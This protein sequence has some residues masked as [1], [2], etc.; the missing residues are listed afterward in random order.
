MPRPASRSRGPWERCALAKEAACSGRDSK[1]VA[2]IRPGI[3]LPLT[4]GASLFGAYFR[5]RF[6]RS[7]TRSAAPPSQIVAFFGLA[8]SRLALVVDG[9]TVPPF[10]LASLALLDGDE[11]LVV[12]IEDRADAADT[13]A[14]AALKAAALPPFSPPAAPPGAAPNPL[15][16]PTGGGGKRRA[17]S[18]PGGAAE[19]DPK[20]GGGPFGRGEPSHPAGAQPPAPAQLRAPEGTTAPPVA[21]RAGAAAAGAGAEAGAGAGAGPSRS[22][23]RKAQKR[24]R[25]REAR[26]RASSPSLHRD[27]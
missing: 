15:P 13:A 18:Q 7:R 4:E 25:R 22:A 6:C 8:E 11:V 9:A 27:P 26:L 23:R 21:A 12:P 2:P 20:G 17:E 5:F 19:R 14:L 3:G 10:A 24:Q 16:L 1:K